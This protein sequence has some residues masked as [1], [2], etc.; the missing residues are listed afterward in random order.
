[1][2]AMITLLFDPIEEKKKKL[3]KQYHIMFPN[4]SKHHLG[5]YNALK[6][7]LIFNIIN[8][9]SNSINANMFILTSIL[10]IPFN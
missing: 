10:L 7:I 4:H 1:M 5:C 3:R 6:R 2:S 8:L 9:S